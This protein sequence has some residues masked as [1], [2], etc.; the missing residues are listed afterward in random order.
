MESHHVNL[1]LVYW[2]PA[3][4][5]LKQRLE[6]LEKCVYSLYGEE[7]EERINTCLCRKYEAIHLAAR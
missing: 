3:L 5:C 2:A 7:I 1:I 6:H 4:V